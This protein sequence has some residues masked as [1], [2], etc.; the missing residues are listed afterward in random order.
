MVLLLLYNN[1]G[2]W[3]PMRSSGKGHGDKQLGL[4]CQVMYASEG[5]RED[6]LFLGNGVGTSL[7]KRSDFA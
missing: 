4:Y 3:Q 1:T 5:S 6:S 7:S 2:V